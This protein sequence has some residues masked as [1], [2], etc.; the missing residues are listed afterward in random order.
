MKLDGKT[1]LITGAA[2]RI[3][4][5]IALDLARHGANLVI[6]Y[7]QSKQDAQQLARQVQGMG[8]QAFLIR[9]DFSHAAGIGKSAQTFVKQVLQKAGAIDVLINNASIF[10]PTP[11]GRIRDS[12]WDSFLSTNLKFPFFLSQALGL[13]MKK[14]KSGKIINLVDWTASRPHPDYLPYAISK[15][16]LIA[17][18]SG[19]ARALAPEVQTACIAPGPILPAEGST[20]ARNEAIRNKTLLKRF[21]DPSDIAAAVRFFIEGS[22][23][24]TGV[25]LPVDGGASLS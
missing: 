25:Y 19:L 20:A 16:G 13:H 21:G 2:K 4:R 3:G 17:A 18:T 7:L 24:V 8:R 23:Y 5:E 15:A 22:D 10:Y 11:I 12:E 1:I 14:R 9:A 6:H